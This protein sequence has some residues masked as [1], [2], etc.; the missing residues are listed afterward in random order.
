MS[1]PSRIVLDGAPRV[2]YD[3]RLCPFPGSLHSV[4]SYL[5][6]L[7]D[8]DY[9]MG[10]T[11]AAFRRLWN[12]DDGGK[13]D[14][15]YQGDRPFA[16][17]FWALGYEWRKIPAE[18]DAMLAAIQES[19]ARGVPAISFGII[20][21]PEAGVVT[22]Y[23]AVTG[24]LYG[25]SY[26][27]ESRD[28]YYEI[29]NWFET[30]D[31]NAGK[32]LIVLGQKQATRPAPREVLIAAL[33]W[34]VDLE[35][36]AHRPGLPDHVGGLAAYEAWAAALEVD[37]DY[38]RAEPQPASQSEVQGDESQAAFWHS[39]EHAWQVMDTRAMVHGDQCTMLEERRSAAMFCQQMA[40]VAPDAAASL[41]EAASLY[42]AAAAQMH[43]AWP[44]GLTHAEAAKGLLERST[45]EGIAAAVRVAAAKEARAVE[46]LER[47]LALLR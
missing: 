47:A 18:K 22:G 5:G 37:A 38:P 44:W 19:L 12:R 34:A 46:H 17:I 45:R 2:G 15:W 3:V 7:C 28:Q 24:A 23:D 11:G 33:E 31:K 43:M 25:W 42:L 10:V 14:L 26:F 8:Y 30:M 16:Q 29:E 40:A 13:I 35:R 39:S 9:I 41:N 36:S 21:P 27:Q 6:D 20:G 4:L 1:V 32:G